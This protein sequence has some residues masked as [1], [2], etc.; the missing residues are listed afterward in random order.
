MQDS[1]G[2]MGFLRG[3][4][5]V[6]SE[7]TQDALA[8]LGLAH[9]QRR[10]TAP[11]G[12]VPDTLVIPRDA[13]PPRMEWIRYDAAHVSSTETSDPEQLRAALA[14][15]EVDWINV[16]GF[17][18]EA[19]MR[20]IGEM[21]GIHPL[22]MADV[23]NVPQRPK[24]DVYA[25]RLLI[26]LRM[27][28][29]DGGDVDLQQVSL[30][31]GP[32]WVITFEEH[33]GDVFDPVRT[34]IHAE[35]SQLRRGG[36]DFLAYALVDAVVDGYLP[37]M[38]GLADTLEELEEQAIGSPEPETLAR[39]HSARRLLL[40]LERVLRQQR[41]ALIALAHGE[42]GVFGETVQ[43]YLRDVQDH[44]IHVL[45]SIETFRE[46]TVGL[47][48]IYLSSV[49]NRT[50]DVMKTLTIIASTFIPLSF[51]AGVYG[52]NFKYMPE[53]H[54]RFGYAGA[55]LLMLSLALSML[56]WFRRRGWLGA[57]A[58]RDLDGLEESEPDESAARAGSPPR[59]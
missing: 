22:A 39:I 13:P 59:A 15:E 33:P 7:A 42:D 23:V 58:S 21:F 4:R 2:R 55:W 47:M 10:R 19:H 28:R 30:V 45:D 51:I 32:G 11:P 31:V 14:T 18:D 16:Q 25:D 20:R 43:P 38:D 5:R 27:A 41:D 35:G 37:V 17:G 48:D 40:L 44:A 53:L 24:V 52:M 9:R 8:Y 6:L 26:V 3:K 49:S 56:F 29:M 50:N 54:W 57:L 46:M 12:A 34:R 36:A 1:S